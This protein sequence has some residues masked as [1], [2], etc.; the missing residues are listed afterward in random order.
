MD[1]RPEFAAWG[2]LARP[3]AWRSDAVCCTSG[4]ITVAARY[5]LPTAQL[6]EQSRCA[7]R[8]P[9]ARCTAS[10]NLRAQATLFTSRAATGAP[11]GYGRRM[12][13][14]RELCWFGRRSE[15]HTSELQSQSNLVCRLLLE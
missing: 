4:P 1:L 11:T 13:R 12:A 9:R 14:Q 10:A 5:G 7:L 15:E 2:S 6:R 8:T 3:T